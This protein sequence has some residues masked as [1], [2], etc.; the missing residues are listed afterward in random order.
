MPDIPIAPMERLLKKA[1][2]G[3]VGEDAKEKL[4]RVLED[5]ALQVGAR[6]NLLAKHAGRRTVRADDIALA[7]R[8]DKIK[9]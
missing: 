7:I 3:R 1:G 8:E 6:A 2:A 4:S 9:K 5:Y